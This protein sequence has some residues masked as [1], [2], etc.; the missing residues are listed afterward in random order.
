MST[1]EN[2]HELVIT[3]EHLEHMAL[4]PLPNAVFFPGTRLPLHIFE[5]RYRQMTREA[6]AENIPIAVVKLT[7]PRRADAKG[8]PAYD[9]IGGAGFLTHHQELPDGRYNILLAGTTRVEIIEE[10]ES[11]K[12]YRVGRARRLPDVVDTSGSINVLMTTLRGCVVGLQSD[13]ERLAEAL[14]KAINNIPD[15]GLL[16]NSISSIIIADPML[17]QQLLEE[18]RPDRRLDEI[19]SRLTDLLAES[20]TPTGESKSWLN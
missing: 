13:Y 10:I 20:S 7:E 19:I 3:E 9:V 1:N 17:R 6:I 4:F 5:P 18:R 2:E 16:A 14:A 8:R 11:E 12:P 15:P